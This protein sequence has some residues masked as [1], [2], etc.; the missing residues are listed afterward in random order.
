[1]W[2]KKR[3]AGDGFIHL[4]AYI[5]CCFLV[6]VSCAQK[7]TPEDQKN[8]HELVIWTYDSFN[9]E[10]GPGPSVSDSFEAKTGIKITWV[11]HGDAGQLLSNLLLEGK[12]AEADI[13]LGLDQNLAPRA[14]GSSLF[15]AYKPK[16]A[17]NIF[18]E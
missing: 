15:E 4:A 1:M 8:T 17:G 18:P 14:L 7:K 13:I 6:L 12:N 3:G 2:G 11:S 9:S 5:A 16:N 10:W